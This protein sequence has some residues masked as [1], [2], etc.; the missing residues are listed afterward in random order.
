MADDDDADAVMAF[1]AL[2]MFA[3]L[4][5]STSEEEDDV[6]RQPTSRSQRHHKEKYIR[7]YATSAHADSFWQCL[8]NICSSYNDTNI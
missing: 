5:S 1:L 4:D 2:S 6:D 7:H 8:S 3:D